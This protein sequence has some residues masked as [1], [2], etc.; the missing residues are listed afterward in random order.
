MER[1]SENIRVVWQG[2]SGPRMVSY[3]D[4]V[5]LNSLHEAQD[6]DDRVVI[7]STSIER[8][9]CPPKK[10]F[11]RGKLLLGGFVIKPIDSKSCI[12]DYFV[13][14]DIGGWIPRFLVNWTNSD[15]INRVIKMR[16]I[17]EESKDEII[18]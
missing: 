7:S 8:E 10:G 2:V 4:F 5:Y 3:R 11:V 14:A 17:I 16:K 6:D 9:D 13:Q 1:Y 15:M 12:I 18:K